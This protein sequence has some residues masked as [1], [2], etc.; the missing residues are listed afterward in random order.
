MGA[1]G[2]AG[3]NSPPPIVRGIIVVG[4][5]V[6][7]GQCRCA[8]SGVIQGFDAR[9]GKLAW[10]WDMQH[11]EWSGYPPKGQ[12]W[13]R[14]TPNSW[15]ISSGDEKLGLVFVPT[16]NVADDYNSTG[17]TPEENAYSV[18]LSRST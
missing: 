13:T 8:P 4:H 10:A 3:I 5:Q 14:G 15:S 2:S 9:T 16:G 6:L 17:R 7:D 11:P 18:Q 1:A 12:M